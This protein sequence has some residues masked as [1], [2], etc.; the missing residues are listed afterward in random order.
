MEI[1]QA[2]NDEYRQVLDFYYDL[3]DA[4]R[5]H[6]YSP[7]WEKKIYPMDEDIQKA[8]EAEELYIGLVNN[9]IAGA[10]VLNQKS[11]D[12]YDKVQWKIHA[13]DDEVMMIHLL[14]ISFNHQQ[15][16]M[17]KQMVNKAI[18][19]AQKQ[20]LKC[21]RLDV[22]ENN[23]SAQKLYPACGFKYIETMKLFYEDTGLINFLMYELEL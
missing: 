18:E 19:L 3:I 10:M 9:D 12:G 1:R 17:A 2:R 4:M 23:L 13:K 11:A 14:G 7:G 5:D 22:M 16:G 21:I 20:S 8:I 6:E 15:K